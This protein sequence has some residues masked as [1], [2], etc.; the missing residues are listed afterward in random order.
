VSNSQTIATVQ[1]VDR[2]GRLNYALFQPGRGVLLLD[3]QSL[4]HLCGGLYIADS[5][6]G[7]HRTAPDGAGMGAQASATSVFEQG[8][9]LR[10]E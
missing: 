10:C 2:A 8:P 3:S 5:L 6:G 7:K 1:P 4:H 9:A